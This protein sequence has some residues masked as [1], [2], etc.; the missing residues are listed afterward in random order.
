MHVRGTA[1][2]IYLHGRYRRAGKI[3]DERHNAYARVI[4]CGYFHSAD[5]DEGRSLTDVERCAVDAFIKRLVMRWRFDLRP[6]LVISIGGDGA[7]FAEE[8]CDGVKWYEGVAV[9]PQSRSGDWRAVNRFKDEALR[10][11][12]EMGPC[13][14]T[15]MQQRG[16]DLRTALPAAQKRSSMT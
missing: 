2:E 8:L 14:M 5:G 13:L 7:H 12:L 6:C 10:G 4:G 16:Y 3:C 11:Y 1:R 9:K 15:V